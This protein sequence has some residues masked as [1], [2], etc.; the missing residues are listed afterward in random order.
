MHLK[1]LRC[2]KKIIGFIMQT[3]AMLT[4]AWKRNC[5]Q[6]DHADSFPSRGALI[7]THNSDEVDFLNFIV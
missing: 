5:P 6:S 4:D 1:S 7:D 2:E 3:L